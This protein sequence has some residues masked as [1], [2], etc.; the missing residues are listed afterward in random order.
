[1]PV[2]LV[3]QGQESDRI[4]HQNLVF[5]AIFAV[6]PLPLLRLAHNTWTNYYFENLHMGS[7]RGQLEWPGLFQ[8]SPEE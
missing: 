7:S 1:M 6:L 4:D 8:I 5:L 3:H 2:F